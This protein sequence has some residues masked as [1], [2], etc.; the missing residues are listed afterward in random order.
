[1]PSGKFLPEAINALHM[2]AS[3]RSDA[4]G[5]SVISKCLAALTALQAKDHQAA[6]DGNQQMQA[7]MSRLGGGGAPPAGGGMMGGGGSPLGE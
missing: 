4:D 6:R 7:V 1:M 5:V 3:E 2:A